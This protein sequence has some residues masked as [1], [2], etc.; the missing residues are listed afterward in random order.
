LLL[1]VAACHVLPADA[2]NMS[3]IAAASIQ[4]GWSWREDTCEAIMLPAGERYA[5][6][7][8]LA[9]TILMGY[10]KAT[11]GHSATIEEDKQ[12]L[13]S[14][15]TCSVGEESGAVDSDEEEEDAQAKVRW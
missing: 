9:G 5:Q 14:V 6:A 3:A 11:I 13:M 12:C 15:E 10:I 2:I 7:M 8:S 4:Y 1:L